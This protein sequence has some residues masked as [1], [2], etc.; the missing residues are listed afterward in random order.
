MRLM[1]PP[2][3]SIMVLLHLGLGLSLHVSLR[4]SWELEVSNTTASFW[5]WT[6]CTCK[7]EMTPI[8]SP[9]RNMLFLHLQ[10]VISKRTLRESWVPD[11]LMPPFKMNTFNTNEPACTYLSPQGQGS[12][13]RSLCGGLKLS[14][15]SRYLYYDWVVKDDRVHQNSSLS[16]R[17]FNLGVPDQGLGFKPLFRMWTIT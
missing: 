15:S 10:Y 5:R 9:T 2:I 16:L 6:P 3:W 4:I 12:R 17:C 8:L 14:G 1:L 11:R 7:R 13:S